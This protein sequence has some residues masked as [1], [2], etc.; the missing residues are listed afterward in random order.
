MTDAEFYA[1]WDAVIEDAAVA[2]D[3]DACEAAMLAL[4]E[5][6]TERFPG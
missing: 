3:D 2:G 1:H 5:A 6:I 4:G